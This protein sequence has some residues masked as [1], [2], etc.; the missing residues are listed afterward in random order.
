MYSQ[1][2]L[3]WVTR[4]HSQP[5][6]GAQ[7]TPLPPLQSQKTLLLPCIKSHLEKSFEEVAGTPASPRIVAPLGPKRDFQNGVQVG[8]TSVP[9]HLL[10][11]YME[12]GGE[13]EMMEGKGAR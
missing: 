5:H 9:L 10:Y 12:G 2:W 1:V 4:A 6:S 8:G 13:T 7:H 3:S 11:K